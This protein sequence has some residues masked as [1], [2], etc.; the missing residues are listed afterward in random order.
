MGFIYPS[1]CRKNI[2]PEVKL[3]RSGSSVDH[4]LKVI[5]NGCVKHKL[6]AYLCL[7]SPGMKVA[8]V[9]RRRCVWLRKSSRSEEKIHS[10]SESSKVGAT[11]PAADRNF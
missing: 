4:L 6:S 2:Y 1:F 8:L 5:C 9:P 7:S 11:D 10:G 3:Q